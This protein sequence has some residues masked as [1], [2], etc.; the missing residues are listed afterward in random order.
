MPAPTPIRTT[1]RGFKSLA[2]NVIL[3][4]FIL[5]G[6]YE[7]L[8]SRKWQLT[9]IVLLS[10]IVYNICMTS[11]SNCIASVRNGF[12]ERQCIERCRHR[13]SLL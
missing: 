4:M 11:K 7:K 5:T 8:E 9:K 10:N 1:G 6:S 13:S 3:M 12:F 2:G